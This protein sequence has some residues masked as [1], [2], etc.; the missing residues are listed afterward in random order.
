MVNMTFIG[1]SAL[2]VRRKLQYLDRTLGM[3]PSQLVYLTFKI[4]HAWESRK[5]KQATVCLEKMCGNQKERQESKGK[6]KDPKYP[7]GANQCAYCKEESHWRKDCPELKNK[8]EK[9]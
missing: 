5:L 1:Q 7:L 8:N 9:G 6:G 4:Y 3:N 2:D